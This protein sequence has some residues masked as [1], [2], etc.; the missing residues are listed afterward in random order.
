MKINVKR[1]QP[2]KKETPL[3]LKKMAFFHH[4]RPDLSLYLHRAKSD[5]DLAIMLGVNTF[6]SSTFWRRIGGLA[7]RCHVKKR[8]SQTRKRFPMIF[9]PIETASRR[10]WKQQPGSSKKTL[11][12]ATSSRDLTTPPGCSSNLSIFRH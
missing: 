9:L 7:Q 1:F 4:T 5:D 3:S 11:S 8:W 12:L 2:F 6:I 10:H